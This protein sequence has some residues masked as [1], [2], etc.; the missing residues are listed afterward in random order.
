[1]HYI[2]EDPWPLGIALLTVGIVSLGALKVTG[3]GKF[4]IWGLAGLSLAALLFVVEALW[5][6][7]DERIEGVVLDIAD[8]AG[9]G[10][11]DRVM[12]HLA[13]DLLLEQGGDTLSQSQT[14]GL[15][16]RLISGAAALV[17]RGGAAHALIRSALSETRFDFLRVGHIDAHANRLSRLGT[18]EFRA[19]ASGSIQASVAQLN[20]ATDASGT[21]WS[22]GFREVEP[23]VWKVTRITAVRLPRGASLSMFG[24]GGRR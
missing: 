9:E 18:A 11:I 13:P 4:L 23:G 12:S 14:R 22:F 5:V 19:Y 17:G 7:D 1:M 10:D 6:T 16:S 3:R 8:A 24:G 20:F 21:D 2:A 15:A